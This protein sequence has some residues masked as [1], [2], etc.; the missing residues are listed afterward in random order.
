MSLPENR[1][2]NAALSPRLLKRTVAFIVAFG[3][4]LIA[5]V[6]TAVVEQ[7]RFERR[8][9]IAAI[10]RQN[11]NRAI[12]FEQYVTR[13]LEAANVA[14]LHLSDKHASIG[15]TAR[16]PRWIDD[17]VVNTDMFSIVS[18]TNEKGDVI[19]T[20]ASPPPVNMNAAKREGFFVD[21]KS[22]V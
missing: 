7:A 19:A 12:A 15:G 6:W 10:V 8:E 20:T 13:T 16:H 21:R 11:T 3:L 17:P 22:V 1:A 2:H 9:A 18:I 4:V 5:L 14:M